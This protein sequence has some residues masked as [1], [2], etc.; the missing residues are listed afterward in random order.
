MGER[1]GAR[2]RR[3]GSGENP[4]MAG[5]MP[6]GREE[7]RQPEAVYGMLL[8]KDLRQRRDIQ[9]PVQLNARESVAL[10][11]GGFC[12]PRDIWQCLETVFIVTAGGGVAVGRQ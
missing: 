8:R 7:G 9:Q 12:P 2:R 6:G 3:K 5:R 1:R 4:R 11:H 10:S